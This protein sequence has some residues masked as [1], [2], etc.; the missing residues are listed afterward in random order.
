MYVNV[1][2]LGRKFAGVETILDRCVQEK[3]IRLVE[4]GGIRYLSR[5]DAYKLRF[6]FHLRNSGVQWEDIPGHLTPG[7]LYTTEAR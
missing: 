2:H 7:H 4:K 6:I 1:E 5:P 3:W